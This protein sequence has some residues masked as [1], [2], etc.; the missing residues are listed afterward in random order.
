MTLDSSQQVF[1]D[2]DNACIANVVPALFG[3]RDD[4][5]VP[6]DARGAN[7]TV[8]LVLDGL[9]FEQFES[10]R[11]MM[12]T[13]AAMAYTPITSVVPSTTASA[14]TSISTGV[15]P[16]EHGIVGYRMMMNGDV[17][18][19]L[20]WTSTHGDMRKKMPPTEVQPRVAFSGRKPIVITK[21]EFASSG[22]TLAHLSGVR[23]RG[24]RAVSALVTNVA[25]ALREGERFVY[26]YYDG[27]DKIAHEYGLAEHYRAELAAA[28]ALVAAIVRVLPTGASLVITA[29]HGQI[30][31]G[32]DVRHI[33]PDVMTHVATQ[34]GEG[35]LR[36]L[37]AK[38]GR[39]GALIQAVRA[40]HGDEAWIYSRSE[41]RDARLFG[42]RMTDA[43]STR[44]GD[45]CLVATG[46]HAFHDPA[47]SGPFEL[48]ARHGSMTSAEMRVPLFAMR[49]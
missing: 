35:R 30:D 2:Y 19:T 38:P 28:D 32:S 23:H 41:A 45:V 20:R 16:S 48:V 17:I 29:D 4:S 6:T 25:V 49:A 46:S 37:H 22:F 5:F 18:N 47:D 7:Q 40:H 8:L 3:L 12:P 26:A 10:F 44:L 9:G 13:L 15:G 1:A 31:T 21:G 43:V 24:W 14:L 33:H 39:S 36:W 27:I 34:S 42:L 11:D